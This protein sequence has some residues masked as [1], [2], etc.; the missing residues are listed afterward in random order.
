M[1]R[2]TQKAYEEVFQYINEHIFELNKAQSFT[3]DY[4]IAMRNALRKLYPQAKLISCYFHYCQAVKRRASQLP[5]VMALIGQNELAKSIY[6]R[7]LCL[8]LLPPQFILEAFKDLC[9]ETSK[10]GNEKSKFRP[11]LQYINDQWMKKVC[12][13]LNY[14]S[15]VAKR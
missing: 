8:P 6:K 9:A 10:L 1:E 7:V 14:L 11:F 2:K 5:D 15:F 3:S 4:E 13:S 12:M